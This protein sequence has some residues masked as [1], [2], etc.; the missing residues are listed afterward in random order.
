M[1]AFHFFK[2]YK[3][4][5]IPQRITNTNYKKQTQHKTFFSNFIQNKLILFSQGTSNYLLQNCWL[6]E[7]KKVTALAFSDLYYFPNLHSIFWI[8][9]S[10]KLLVIRKKGQSQNGCYKKTKHA[11]SSKKQTFLT[12]WYTHARVRIRGEEMFV[13]PKNWHVLFP[14]NTLFKTRPLVYNRWINIL[15]TLSCILL[16]RNV[17]PPQ[18]IK[19]IFGHFEFKH[20][21]V[22][23][24][25]SYTNKL[26]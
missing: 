26:Q 18:D 21:K 16:M 13:F 14:C 2:F 23:T 20:E 1:G 24:D 15:L 22:K 9:I 25:L 11:K 17:F 5:Q 8:L 12:P 3:W 4:C 10:P 7:Y 19:S 6:N